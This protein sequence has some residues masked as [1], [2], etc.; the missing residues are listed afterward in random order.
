MYEVKAIASFDHHGSRRAGDRFK[1]GSKRQADELA[2]KGL[3]K[4]IGEAKESDEA[5]DSDAAPVT[6]KRAASKKASQKA[7]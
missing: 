5:V 7:D 1:V 2:K 6:S 3:V 4:V